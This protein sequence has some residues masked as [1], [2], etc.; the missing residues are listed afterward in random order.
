MCKKYKKFG[1]K[2]G[3]EYYCKHKPKYDDIYSCKKNYSKYFA[4]TYF[5]FSILYADGI[6]YLLFYPYDPNIC[7]PNNSAFLLRPILILAIVYIM[8]MF[9]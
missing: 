6:L 8:I 3:K 9:M 4:M 2:H 5:I 7:H 1:S